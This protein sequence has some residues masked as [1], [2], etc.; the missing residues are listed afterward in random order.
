[1][2]KKLNC[3]QDLTRAYLSYSFGNTNK[4]SL[5]FP[6][7]CRKKQIRLTCI[8]AKVSLILTAALACT[9]TGIFHRADN[10]VDL[11]TLAAFC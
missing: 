9:E 6:F 5:R 2:K 8:K 1:M 11:K 10:L 7:I 3:I 4:N